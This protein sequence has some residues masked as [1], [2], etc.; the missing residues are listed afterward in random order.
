MSALV[1]ALV[2]V[3]ER[4]DHLLKDEYVLVYVLLLLISLFVLAFIEYIFEKLDD[5]KIFRYLFSRQ[6]YIEGWWLNYAVDGKTKGIYNFAL[7]EISF[8]DGKHLVSGRAFKASIKEGSKPEVIE[9]G[10]FHSTLSQYKGNGELRFNFTITDSGKVAASGH[11]IKG[12][13]KFLFVK[14]GKIPSR[15][16]GT[17]NTDKPFGFCSVTGNKLDK[18]IASP[19]EGVVQIYEKALQHAIRQKWISTHQLQQMSE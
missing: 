8:L 19:D 11:E 9:D 3:K 5:S 13:A 4:L 17:F 18:E 2:E 7:I 10:H 6:D 16:S 12:K 1:V 14:D 15:F